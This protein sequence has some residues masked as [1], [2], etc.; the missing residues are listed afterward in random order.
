MGGIYVVKIV[1][2]TGGERRGE[3]KRIG[4]GFEEVTGQNYFFS[5]FGY[6][7]FYYNLLFRL[8]NVY[9]VKKNKTKV[10][11]ISLVNME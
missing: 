2:C 6:L 7:L 1:L 3:G 4:R 11:K 10:R 5:D 8:K 9:N